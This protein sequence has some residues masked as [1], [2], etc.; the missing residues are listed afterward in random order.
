MY[1]L[2]RK[3]SHQIDTFKDTFCPLTMGGSSEGLERNNSEGPE[4]H[5]NLWIEGPEPDNRLNLTVV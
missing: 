3:A 4:P 2:I 5:V 1:F